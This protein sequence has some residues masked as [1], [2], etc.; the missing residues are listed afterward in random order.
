MDD[1]VKFVVSSKD[2]K[3]LG[4][5]LAFTHTFANIRSPHDGLVS[6][7]D[8]SVFDHNFSFGTVLGDLQADHLELFLE[9]PLLFIPSSQHHTP[10]AFTR[11]LVIHILRSKQK[12]VTDYKNLTN[13]LRDERL[14]RSLCRKAF[15]VSARQ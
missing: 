15:I 2:P 1:A 8:M 13:Q 4:P 5:P 10:A 14:E 9:K 11:A 12:G 3:S 7:R 6:R